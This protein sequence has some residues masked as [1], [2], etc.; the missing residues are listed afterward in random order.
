M[1]ASA[2]GFDFGTTNSVLA[3]AQGDTTR[4][5]TFTSSAGETQ[6]MRTAL[7]F[8]KQTRQNASVLNVEAGQAAIRMFIDN[9]GD[10]RFLQSIKTFAA[11]AVFQGT[12]IFGKRHGFEDLMETFLARIAEYAGEDWAR[13][14]QRLVVG[15]PVHFAGGNPDE[16]LA[17]QRYQAALSRF[18]FPQVHYV[19]EPVAAAFF[20]AQNLKQDATV[21]VADFGGGTT[22]YSIIRFETH[23]G[24]LTATPVGH[25]GVGVA[26]DHFDFRII[27]T[28]VAPL[29][30]KGSKFRSF[31][32]R[33]DVPSS[34]YANFGRWNQLSIFKTLKDFTELQKLVRVAEE[35]EKLEAFIDLVEQDEGYPLYQAVSATKM[36]LS[37]D[38][39]TEFYFA[40]LGES[41]R[42]TVRRSDFDS[43][44]A[45]DLARIEAALDDVLVKTNTA[46]DT[47]DKVFLTGGTSFVPA[48]RTIFEQ[49]FAA[50]RIETG[51]ELLSIAHGLA[52]IG[53][54]DDIERWTAPLPA[55]AAA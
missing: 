44:I 3:A 22:D 39:E 55:Q 49:R 34:Y 15:R 42:Q 41:S 45:P 21:L 14:Y 53:E 50:D 4:S 31:D 29:I 6:S 46:P 1:T 24:Q 12:L 7:S 9:P 38:T 43:W 35:P 11:S 48:V 20:F 40:P 10:C 27:D 18:D 13:G 25:S 2:L 52:L 37:Q 23:A 36:R 17:L 26:G 5:L 51:G 19:Y 54:R 8:M 32:K 33:L 16:T 47:I 30:G 28:I